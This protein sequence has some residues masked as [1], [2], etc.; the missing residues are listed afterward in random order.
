MRIERRLSPEELTRVAKLLGSKVLDLFAPTLDLSWPW[1]AAPSFSISIGSGEFLAIESEREAISG[2]FVDT[3][4]VAVLDHPKDVPRLLRNGK[5]IIGPPTSKVQIDPPPSPVVELA[6]LERDN[7]SEPV[8][9]WY[10]SALIF[11]LA[12]RR[13]FAIAVRQPTGR[14]ECTLEP[15]AIESLFSNCKVRTALRQA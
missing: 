14:V 15:E 5:K 12:D 13:R 2:T 11:T 7:A 3:L 8:I 1:C 4:R 9:I 10:D 6:I